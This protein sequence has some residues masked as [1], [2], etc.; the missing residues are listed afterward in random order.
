[1]VTVS[2]PGSVVH[3]TQVGASAPLAGPSLGHAIARGYN[4]V[5]GA[6]LAPAVYAL[7]RVHLGRG[8]SLLVRRKGRLKPV[9]VT[10]LPYSGF[11]TDVQAQLMALMTLA[12]GISIIT[13]RIFESRFPGSVPSTSTRSTRGRRYSSRVSEVEGLTEIPSEKPASRI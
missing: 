1:M 4:A 11:P 13:E 5:L 6:A 3:A 7:A 10:T 12:P 9:D 2:G 8:A